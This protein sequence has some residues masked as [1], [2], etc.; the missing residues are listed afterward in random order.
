M[1]NHRRVQEIPQNLQ[2]AEL[3][4]LREE[5]EA[6]IIKI[7]GKKTTILVQT[8][9]ILHRNHQELDIRWGKP[10]GAE[11]WD[12]ISFF[13]P[14]FLLSFSAGFFLQDP[15]NTSKRR[16]F[17]SKSTFYGKMLPA[18]LGAISFVF[19]F[20]FFLFPLFLANIKW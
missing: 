4:F 17:P 6:R 20:F 3:R 13:F 7:V 9:T 14:H 15:K 11:L 1:E 19:F 10:H 16:I 2:R 5:E 12:L 18:G 8:A